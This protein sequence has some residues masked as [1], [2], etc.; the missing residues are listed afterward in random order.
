MSETVDVA[1]APGM[2]V[3]AP[4][5]NGKAD[6]KYEAADPCIGEV[7]LSSEEIRTRITELGAELSLAY[8]GKRPVLV[9]VLKGSYIFASDLSRALQA[10]HEVEFIRARSYSGTASTGSVQITGLSAVDLRG[11]HVLV[12]EDIV[13]TGLTL[14][15]IS[16]EISGRGAVS[17]RTVAFVSKRTKRRI[18]G[19]PPVD[20][21]AFEVPDKF[22]V[23]YGLDID[24][25]LRHLP[26]V[27]LYNP[28]SSNIGTTTNPSDSDKTQG[29]PS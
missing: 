6:A 7:L 13:D 11:R 4:V 16:K 26:N 10:A 20:Y 9:V 29:T 12:V 1:G 27:C 3:G 8:A 21:H 18:D 22:I 2:G 17:V 15:S 5:E 23:G 25:R 14:K 24:Q 28:P 19:T